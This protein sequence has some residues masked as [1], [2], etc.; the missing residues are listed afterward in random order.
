V[1]VAAISLLQF[2]AF[3]SWNHTFFYTTQR[4]TSYCHKN[5]WHTRHLLLHLPKKN[6][7]TSKL[8]ILENVEQE[9]IAKIEGKSTTSF[10]LFFY[11]SQ[12]FFHYLLY[13]Y[14]TFLFFLY[15]NS[16][17]FFNVG[18]P[19]QAFRALLQSMLDCKGL[20]NIISCNKRISE[21]LELTR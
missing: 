13:Y 10:L 14:V 3:F 4:D 7:M 19:E 8:L 20:V 6:Y 21:Q 2:Y 11:Y 17:F 5:Y 15:T 1:S 16:S 18:S 12:T 9:T